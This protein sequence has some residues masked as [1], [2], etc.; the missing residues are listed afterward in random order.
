MESGRWRLPASGVNAG[1]G[2]ARGEEEGALNGIDLHGTGL[3][4]SSGEDRARE[5]SAREDSADGET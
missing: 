4:A 3:E 1:A 5:D 2:E